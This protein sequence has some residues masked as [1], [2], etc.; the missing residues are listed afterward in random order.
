[1]AEE[2]E[3]IEVRQKVTPERLRQFEDAREL[4]GVERG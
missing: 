1:L 4:M 3:R 2:G